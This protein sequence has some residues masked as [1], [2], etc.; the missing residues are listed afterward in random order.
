MDEGFRGNAMFRN[1]SWYISSKRGFKGVASG[2]CRFVWI[3]VEEIQE[4]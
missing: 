1:T 2:M 4:M 3:H